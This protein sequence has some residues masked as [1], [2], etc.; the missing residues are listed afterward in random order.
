MPS[1]CSFSNVALKLLGYIVGEDGISADPEKLKAIAAL[2]TPSTVS[3]L[4]TFLGMSG[5]YRVEHVIH[6]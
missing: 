3:Q 4:R 1:K 2:P 6:Y 5:Y